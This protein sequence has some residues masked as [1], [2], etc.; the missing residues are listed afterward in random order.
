MHIYDSSEAHENFDA[1]NIAIDAT[2]DS[3]LNFK[4][5]IPQ[6]EKAIEANKK[7][8]VEFQ[9][10]MDPLRFNFKDQMQ[11]FGLSIAIASFIEVLYTPY[12]E[13]FAGVILYRG[14]GDFSQAIKSHLELEE[15]YDEFKASAR[16]D[17]T[18][19]LYLFSMQILM[20]YLHRLG[21]ALPESLDMF[22]MLN[23]KGVDS[24]TK[25]AELLAANHFPY[26]KPAV[27]GA[28]VLFEG[29]TWDQGRSF[30]GYIGKDLSCFEKIDTPH[31]A[32][33]LPPFGDVDYDLMD[34]KIEQI[35]RS[36]ES[37][38]VIPDDMLNESWHLIDRLVVFEGHISDEGKRMIDG[39]IAA[40]GEVEKVSQEVM[41]T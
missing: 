35:N 39:F 31:L 4:E 3:N 30:V 21:A 7:I 11:F 1:V 15:L 10:G 40:G 9:F 32:I 17:E 37:Y 27:K 19:L 13:H 18:Y 8:F 20:E 5:V 38:K 14:A 29:L 36:G 23:L 26:I 33:L 6:I 25:Q 2:D 34:Q 12:G 41:Q 22:V 16:G 28:K 24:P